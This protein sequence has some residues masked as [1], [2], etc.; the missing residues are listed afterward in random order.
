[1][2]SEIQQNTITQQII[3]QI[4]TAILAG[5]L[6]AGDKLPSENDMIKQF[7]ISKQTLRES[8]RALEHMGLLEMRKGMGGGSFIIEVDSQITKL[9]LLNYF[10]FKNLSIK[11]LSQVRRLIE[12]NSARLAAKNMSD[13]NILKLKELNTSANKHLNDN[14]YKALLDC[15]IAFH[16]KISEVTNNPLIGLLMEFI[17]DIVVDYKK[18]FEVGIDYLKVVLQAHEKIYQAIKDRDENQAYN[19]MLDHIIDLENNLSTKENNMSLK[20]VYLEK[21]IKN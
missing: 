7:N 12:P 21:N 2:F 8:L 18:L 6:A 17:E 14:N 9:S 1:M 3:H 16:I 4:H 13:E 11:D 10:Y 20:D 15:E 5:K 19:E